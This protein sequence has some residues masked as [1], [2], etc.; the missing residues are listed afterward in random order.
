MNIVCACYRVLTTPSISNATPAIDGD[1]AASSKTGK[2]LEY[3]G[4]TPG[5]TLTR[6]GRLSHV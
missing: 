6:D 1:D 4:R 3:M 2:R 5:K